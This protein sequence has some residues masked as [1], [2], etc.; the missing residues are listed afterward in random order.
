MLLVIRDVVND[1]LIFFFS[2]LV[3]SYNTT[4][5]FFNSFTREYI[6]ISCP[7]VSFLFFPPLPLRQPDYDILLYCYTVGPIGALSVVLKRRE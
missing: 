5:V 6:T 2:L 4:V 7:L 3:A 1:V